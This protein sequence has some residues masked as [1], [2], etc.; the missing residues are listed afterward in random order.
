MKKAKQ[1]KPKKLNNKVYKPKK[2]SARS[3]GYDNEWERYRFRFLHHNPKCYKCGVKSR[4][5]DHIVP[6]KVDPEVYFWKVD[7]Y[8]PLCDKCHNI[9]TGKFDRHNPPKTE[10]KMEYLARFRSVN[11]VNHSVK[12]VPFKK[13]SGLGK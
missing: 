9:I 1:Y 5:V 6:A 2:A 3:K 11:N 7:N 12:I 8:I 13:G 4:V 10:E